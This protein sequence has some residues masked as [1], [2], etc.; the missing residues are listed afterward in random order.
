MYVCIHVHVK[1]ATAFLRRCQVRGIK[2]LG[3]KASEVDDLSWG[4]RGG[5]LRSGKK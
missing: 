2:I 1:R 4:V 3:N 5:E